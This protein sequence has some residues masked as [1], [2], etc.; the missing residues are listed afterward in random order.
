VSR[1]VTGPGSCFLAG[2]RQ[3]VTGI[4]VGES[5]PRVIPGQLLVFRAGIRRLP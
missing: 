5:P 1:P 3:L 4:P 2:G